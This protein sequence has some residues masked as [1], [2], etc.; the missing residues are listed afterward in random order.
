MARKA[1]QGYTEKS[2]YDNTKFLGTVATNDP[3]SEG[4]FRQLVNFDIS[5]TGQ[6]LTPRKGF[7]TTALCTPGWCTHNFK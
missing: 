4:Y 1:V 2:Y 6:S 7:I 3:V 5:D